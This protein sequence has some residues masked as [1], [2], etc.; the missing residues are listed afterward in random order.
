MFD[1]Q[2]II[3]H[4]AE[5]IRI[6]NSDEWASLELRKAVIELAENAGMTASADFIDHQIVLLTDCQFSF[7]DIVDYEPSDQVQA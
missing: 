2:R 1:R 6:A 5:V 7:N 3:D 4:A